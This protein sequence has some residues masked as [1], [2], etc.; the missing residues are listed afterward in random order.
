[1]FINHLCPEKQKIRDYIF[2]LALKQIDSN[3]Q[4]VAFTLPSTNFQLEDKLIY[5][6]SYK[7]IAAENNSEVYQEQL[8]KRSSTKNL[9][10]NFGD[11]FS[12]LSKVEDSLDLIWLDL[13]GP[14][15]TRV[16]NNF[17]STIQTVKLSKTAYVSITY[18]ARREVQSKALKQFYGIDLSELRNSEFPKLVQQFGEMAGR[19]VTVIKQINYKSSTKTKAMGMT[20]ITFKIKTK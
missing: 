6:L 8:I 16:I 15:S 12:I 20:M 1:M 10:L 5:N 9:E 7:V 4:S 19:K 3:R 13:C 11:A 2:K 17:L 14:L 18:A